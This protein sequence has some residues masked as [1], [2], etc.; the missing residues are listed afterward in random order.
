MLLIS[1]F[2]RIEHHHH[3]DKEF[4]PSQQTAKATMDKMEDNDAGKIL[5]KNG[6]VGYLVS[7]HYYLLCWSIPEYYIA[8]Q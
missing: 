5:F 2:P 6:N 3:N 1:I 7:R 8:T 4:L